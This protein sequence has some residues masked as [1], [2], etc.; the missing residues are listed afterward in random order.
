MSVLILDVPLTFELFVLLPSF[1]K[2]E[3]S[4]EQVSC[5]N[6]RR[7]REA[8]KEGR[9]KGKSEKEEGNLPIHVSFLTYGCVNI[10]TR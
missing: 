3:S 8:R 7:M 9:K 4:S 1:L 2:M 5:E 10:R 6:R